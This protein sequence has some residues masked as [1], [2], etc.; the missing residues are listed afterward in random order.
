MARW[1]VE[2]GA[3]FGAGIDPRVNAHV[4]ARIADFFDPATIA[5]VRRS[6]AL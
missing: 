6:L 2:T 1:K 3:S 5:R 4:A